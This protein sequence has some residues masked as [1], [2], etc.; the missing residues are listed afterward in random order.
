MNIPVLRP[1]CYHGENSR[2]PFFEGWYFKSVSKDLNH[3]LVVIPGVY[4]STN[5][6]LD[7]CFIQIFDSEANTVN[8]HKYPISMF[9]SSPDS[10]EIGIGPNYFSSTRMV[11]DI[12]DEL[13]Q[14]KGSLEFTHL[15]PWPTK[16]L[17]PGAMGWFGWIPFM[18]CY[19]GVVSMDHLIEGILI[20]NNI[21]FD[22]SGGRGYIEK[23]WGKQF[24]QA[25]IWG[26]SNHFEIPETSIMVSL[27]VIP[28]LGWAFPGFIIGFLFNGVLHRFSTYNRSKVEACVI[29]DDEINLIVHNSSHKLTIN[30]HRTTG[31]LLHAPTLISM[32]RRI[33]E[34]LD[35]ELHLIL[36]DRK[37]GVIFQGRGSN[38]GLEAVGDLERLAAMIK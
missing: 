17:S 26:Q 2:P 16:L 37:K 24:P 36:Q 13:S 27:A 7:H 32:D 30:A 12:N 3:S 21:S 23:D 15:H 10:F 34:S 35:A 38:S 29:K 22:F 9:K 4:K 11:L 33:I 8:F 19:H 20:K 14:I 18:E 5:K 1:E 28:W 25:W 31:G 6:K